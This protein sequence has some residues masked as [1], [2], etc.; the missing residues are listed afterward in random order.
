M[1]VGK[2]FSRDIGKRKCS[3]HTEGGIA[4]KPLG[5]ITTHWVQH[6]KSIK[7]KISIISNKI[8]SRHHVF[9]MASLSQVCTALNFVYSAVHVLGGAGGRAYWVW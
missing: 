4:T 2:L 3:R 6:K 7:A 8:G 1:G 5:I 9:H